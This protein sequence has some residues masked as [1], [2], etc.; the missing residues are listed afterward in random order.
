MFRYP[1]NPFQNH[2]QK[3]AVSISIN[4]II[5]RSLFQEKSSGSPRGFRSWEASQRKRHELES[6][7]GWSFKSYRRF[8][9]TIGR[10]IYIYIYTLPKTNRSPLKIHHFDDIYQGFDVFIG[11][12][13]VF[14]GVYI[15]F[16]QVIYLHI[17]VYIYI[18]ILRHGSIMWHNGIVPF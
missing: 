15:M 11:E 1:F 7:N 17:Y 4:S 14:E 2:L 16:M 5:V 9:T 12:L 10:Y 8:E 13:L 18:Y 6:E 3:G